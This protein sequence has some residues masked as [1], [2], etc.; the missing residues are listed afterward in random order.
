MMTES[1]TG[2]T[3]VIGGAGRTGRLV[4]ERLLADGVDVRVVSRHATRAGDLARA[5]A[6][7]FDVDIRDGKGLDKALA[8]STGVVY[9][10]EP[11]TSNS[12]PNSPET[13]MYQGVRHALAAGTDLARFVLVSQ[14]YVTRSNHPMN[15]YGRLLDWRLR[16]EDAVRASDVAHTVV[17]PSW[18]TSGAGGRTGISLRQGD[19]GDGKVSRADV[20]EAC[21]RALALESA[22]NTTFE[23]YNEKGAPPASWDELFLALAKD[24]VSA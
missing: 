18:L 19:D 1:V 2:P 6:R 24:K 8:G 9:V 20:A 12:G 21:V 17:R 23:M 10:I 14:I 13:T 5:G 15:Q 7:L 4:T 3:T 22:M 16:G 11:G